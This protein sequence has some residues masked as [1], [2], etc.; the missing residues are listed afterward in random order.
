VKLAF[1]LA[2]QGLITGAIYALIAVGL[3]MVFGLLRILHVAHA[4][5]F[6]LGGYLG[7]VLTNATGSL[8]V[9]LPVAMIVIGVVGMAIYRLCYEPILSEPPYVALIASIGLF[10][11][12]EEVYRIAFGAYGLSYKRPPL[13][14]GVVLLGMT[15]KHAEIAVM[16]AAVVLLSGL[17]LFATR[18]RSGMAW[19]ATVTDPAMAAS[20]GVDI[21]RVRY[22]TFFIGSALAS[23][24]GVMVGILNNLVEPTMGEV[25]SYKALA[26]IVLGGL[27][28]VKGTLVAAL[29]LGVVEAF[30]AIYLSALLDR[31]AIAFAALLAVLLVRPQGLL[32]R[33]P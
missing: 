10:I 18:T 3:A 21:R 9:G 27:G 22:L 23:A 20:C 25:P 1:D 33:M 31:N 4:G 32:V 29:F 7:L 8:L 6:A 11:A 14:G 15:V 13:S 12:M 17:H 26:I 2:F 5:L 28:D 24:A 30:G 19:R 16:V